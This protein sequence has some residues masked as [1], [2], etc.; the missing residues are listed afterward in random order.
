[1]ED[2]EAAIGSDGVDAFGE[3]DFDA[4]VGVD[5]S[6]WEVILS[7]VDDEVD[8][9]LHFDFDGEESAVGEIDF[10]APPGID[11]DAWGAI[12]SSV[13]K[14][15]DQALGLD[16]FDEDSTSESQSG[17]N[18]FEGKDRVEWDQLIKLIGSKQASHFFNSDD[19]SGESSTSQEYNPD[20]Y[21]EVG[22]ADQD[23]D[24]PDVPGVDEEM[25]TIFNRGG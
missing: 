16:Y 21:D 25:L 10:D 11:N 24:L 23:F 22:V 12:L 13:D 4:P 17:K 7:A 20:D 8:R 2:F 6:L 9:A 1:M 15:V 14:R 19:Y 3:V 5:A 18:D